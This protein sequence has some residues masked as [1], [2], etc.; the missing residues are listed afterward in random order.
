MPPTWPGI[1]PAT[2]GIEGQRYTNCANQ[3]NFYLLMIQNSTHGGQ[4]ITPTTWNG[5]WPKLCVPESHSTEIQSV[6]TWPSTS[7]FEYPDTEFN[8]TEEINHM[9]LAQTDEEADFNSTVVQSVLTWPST[10]M[11]STS[12]YEN[13]GTELNVTEEINHME[14]AQTDKEA[15]LSETAHSLQEIATKAVITPTDIGKATDLI[16]K[17]LQVN[18]SILTYARQDLT[19]I[20]RSLDDVLTR[21][22]LEPG[23][24]VK[25]VTTQIAVFVINVEGQPSQ[26]ITLT[27]SKSYK[28]LEGVSL[29][30]ADSYQQVM[31]SEVE[32]GVWLPPSLTNNTSHLAFTLF[33]DD[34]AFQ[35]NAREN[36]QTNSYILGVNVV[37]NSKF[38]CGENVNII[39]KPQ[40]LLGDKQCVF[41]DFTLNGEGGW[42]TEGCELIQS[43]SSSQDVCRCTHLT[44]F[45]EIITPPGVLVDPVHR[46]ALDIISVVGCSLSLMG[47]LGIFFTGAAFRQW[48]VQLGNKILLHLSAAIALNMLVFLITTTGLARTRAACIVL[49]V[50]L[51]YSVL[52]SFCWMLV[53]AG[54]QFMRLVSVFG[55]QHISHLLLKSSL[56]AWGVPLLPVCV[57]LVVDVGLYNQD[58]RE[59]CYPIGLAF[60]LAVLCPVLLIIITNVIVFGMILRTIF[61][62]NSVKRHVKAEQTLLIRRVAT[63]ILLFFLLG[64]S[65]VFGL[66]SSLSTVFAYLFCIT[67]TLQGFVL[68]LFFVL[69]EK[70]SRSYW[71]NSTTNRNFTSTTGTPAER[72][73]LYR[74]GDSIA[75]E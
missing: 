14:L 66:L 49:G 23:Q 27:G 13:P 10:D 55:A 17:V 47:L 52:V 15:N 32:V 45:A 20:I 6:V 21:V 34:A 71:I 53:S 61:A 33:S 19:S 60:Y 11:E 22:R 18:H 5:D 67:A 63:S 4:Y 41:W 31:S 58:A 38:P 72:L 59:F 37:G 35:D 69:G 43:N 75:A 24:K 30:N 25:N 44:H 29:Q 70:K 51:H 40:K 54:L 62:G 9:E 36:Y 57:L 68:F 42:S 50:I 26:G 74:Q 28:D 2:L 46:D 64:L 7:E 65:W 39:F 73:V 56:F 16:S 1:E 8:V 3:V 48:R 12:E